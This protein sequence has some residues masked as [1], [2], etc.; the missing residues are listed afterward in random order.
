MDRT[1]PEHKYP[2]LTW[3]QSMEESIGTVLKVQFGSVPFPMNILKRNQ[4]HTPLI[5]AHDFKLTFT[6]L[7]LIPNNFRQIN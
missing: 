3:N 7:R 6:H 1:E 2:E 4:N 5:P